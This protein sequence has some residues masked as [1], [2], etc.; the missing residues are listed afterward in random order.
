MEVVYK[1]PNVYIDISGLVLGNFND[2]FERYV[3]KEIE[4]MI[5]SAG[6]P[7]YLLYGA[8]W[9]ISNMKSYLKFMNQLDLAEDKK[10]LILWE[11]TAKLF[12]IDINELK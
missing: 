8:D 5:T 3:K 4:E 1:N 10:E 11:N 6:D 7:K 9:P 12:K 2:K